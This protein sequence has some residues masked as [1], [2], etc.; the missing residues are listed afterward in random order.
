MTVT[1]LILN[2]EY[3][4]ITNFSVVVF[5][6]V[7]FWIQFPHCKFVLRSKIHLFDVHND[8]VERRIL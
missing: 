6:V 4:T 3:S 7:L 2:I 5:R 1:V 8:S